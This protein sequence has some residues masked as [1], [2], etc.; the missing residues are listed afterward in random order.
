MREYVERYQDPKT[1]FPEDAITKWQSV[2]VNTYGCNVNLFTDENCENGMNDQFIYAKKG[3]MTYA[4]GFKGKGDKYR[5]TEGQCT[6][7]VQTPIKCIR[8][9]KPCLHPIHHHEKMKK[10]HKKSLVSS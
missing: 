3:T 1:G 6:N 9:K 10:I 7:L 2:H 8:S 4:G 5:N